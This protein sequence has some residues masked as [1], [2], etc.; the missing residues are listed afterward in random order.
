[1]APEGDLKMY[2]IDFGNR[3]FPLFS[4]LNIELIGSPRPFLTLQLTGAFHDRV[5]SSKIRHNREYEVKTN[6]V[7][8]S[9]L[10]TEAQRRRVCVVSLLAIVMDFAPRAKNETT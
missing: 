4:K 10:N 1:M 3:I 2:L 9:L 6:W 5:N 8:V 7:D